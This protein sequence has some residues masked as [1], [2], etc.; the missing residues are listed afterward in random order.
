[1]VSKGSEIKER[2]IR[3]FDISLT[4][5]Q[6]KLY[7]KEV[8]VRNEVTMLADTANVP[9]VL[10]GDADN[11]PFPL[12]PGSALSLYFTRPNDV[13]VKMASATGTLHV[14]FGGALF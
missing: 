12:T 2:S 5:T 8:T 6:V 13:W 10:V 3:A 4:T 11:Q 9:N 7:D 14:I 1:M